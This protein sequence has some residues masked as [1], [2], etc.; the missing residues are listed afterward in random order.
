MRVVHS[1]GKRKISVY[2]W[3][4]AVMFP[5][6]YSIDEAKVTNHIK[7]KIDEYVLHWIYYLYVHW[8]LCNFQFAKA[9]CHVGKSHFSSEL[10]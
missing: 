8:Y 2:K 7:G 4:G 1:S 3:I 10:C 6:H 5:D 9:V